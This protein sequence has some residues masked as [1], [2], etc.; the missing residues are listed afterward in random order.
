M[1]LITLY[2]VHT[3]NISEVG[4]CVSDVYNLFVVGDFF[5]ENTFFFKILFFFTCAYA[6]LFSFDFI[7][8]VFFASH[9]THT[10]KKKQKRRNKDARI[11]KERR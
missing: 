10:T 3:H 7:L 11:K 4:K 1:L 8:V 2:L 6:D 5:F 9:P